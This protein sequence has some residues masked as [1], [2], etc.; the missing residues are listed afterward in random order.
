[1][2]IFKFIKEESIDNVKVWCN[3][4]SDKINLLYKR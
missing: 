3:T 4:N 1:M 2:E